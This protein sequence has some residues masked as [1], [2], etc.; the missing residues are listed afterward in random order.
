MIQTVV[1]AA[2]SRYLSCWPNSEKSQQ[3]PVVVPEGQGLDGYHK[4]PRAVP[5]K[6]LQP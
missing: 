1:K 3:G 2:V 5:V 4:V 6:P